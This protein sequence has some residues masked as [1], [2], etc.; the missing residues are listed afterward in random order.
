M[1]EAKKES[2]SR[3]QKS[4]CL[5]EEAPSF[6]AGEDDPGRVSSKS[7][8]EELSETS[9][10]FAEA[11]ASRRQ[12]TLVVEV[13]N[14]FVAPQTYSEAEID[15]TE[16][17]KAMNSEIAS[18]K[19]NQNWGRVDLPEGAKSDCHAS[20]FTAS[21]KLAPAKSSSTKQGS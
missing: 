8:M 11:C 3:E 7:F 4:E 15:N 12:V 6:T 14:V 18:R 10:L 16:W 20:G 9:P 19:G 21:K 5:E 13:F 17:R 2:E 1:E